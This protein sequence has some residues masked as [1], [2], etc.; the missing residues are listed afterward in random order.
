MSSL[1]LVEFSYVDDDGC[2]VEFGN[3]DDTACMEYALGF[4][5]FRRAE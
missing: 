5:H 2:F 4:F 3:F 1:D